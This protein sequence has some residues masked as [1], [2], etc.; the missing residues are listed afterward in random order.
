Q[1]R[2]GEAQKAARD[3]I[4]NVSM[5]A[6]RSVPEIEFFIP[7]PLF[8]LARFG[9]WDDILREPQPPSDL[10][11]SVALWHY[12]R[13]LAYTAKGQSDRAEEERQELDRIADAMPAERIVG[14]NS[15]A[16]ILRIAS[17]VV[18]GHIAATRGRIEDAIRHFK[19]AVTLQ[20][21]LRYYEP[22]DWYYPVREDLGAALL[23]AG[24]AAEAEAVY[25]EDLKRTPENPWSL[26][27]LVRSLLAQ[28]ADKEAA[29]VEERFRKAW[30]RADLEFRPSRFEAFLASQAG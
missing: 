13:G 28:K 6:V 17:H 21:G 19:E 7:T 10:R 25:R 12:A 30:S 1:G 16:K 18:S 26:Y 2:S 24:R 27:G 23:A 11:Y 14:L 4:R 8:A 9:Q 5:E 29:A 3:L 15:A 20:D 22:P